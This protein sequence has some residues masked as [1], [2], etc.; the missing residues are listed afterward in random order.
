M[1][2][3]EKNFKIIRSPLALQ[4]LSKKILAQGKSIGLVPTMGAL[5]KGHI[6]LVKKSAKS[7]DVT[8]VSVFVNPVQFGANEDFA[9]YP[10]RLQTDAK[11]CAE[12]GAD[13]IFAPSS[14]DMYPAPLQTYVRSAIENMYCG[15]YRPGHFTGVLSVVAKLFNIALP[16]NAYFGEKD[17]QQLHVIRKMAYDLN[18]PVKV[19]GA[20]TIREKSGLAMSSRNEYMSCEERVAASSIYAG[21]QEAKKMYKQGVNSVAKLKKIISEKIEEAGGKIQYIEMANKN[22]LVPVK[23]KISKAAVILLACYFGKTRLIDCDFLYYPR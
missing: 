13:I 4:R 15:A 11:L 19:I 23:T 3:N 1:R 8:I 6:S 5:H 7:N 2:K 16:S 14:K 20:K 17:F 9:K 12:S 22:D 21:M 18:F 10:R